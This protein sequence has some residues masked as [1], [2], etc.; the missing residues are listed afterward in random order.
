MSNLA[1]KVGAALD[2]LIGVFTPR[3]A[4]RRAQERLRALTLRGFAA[5]RVDSHTGNWGASDRHINDLLASDGARLRARVR[6]L[7]R[8]F[9]LFAR[10]VDAAVNITVSNGIKF[11][12][13]VTRPDGKLDK[14]INARVEEAW[15]EWCE[16]PE[17]SGRL[18]F[19]ELQRLLRR[20]EMEVGEALAVMALD[21]RT[22]TGS[23]A[24]M[25]QPYEPDWLSSYGAKPPR[26][27]EVMGGVEIEKRSG[28]VTAYWLEDPERIGAP[29]RIPADDVL[30]SY[31]PLR[32]GQLRGVSPL[33]PA[34]MSARDIG[35]YVGA[36]VEG[37]MMAA[38]WLAKRRTSRGGIPSPLASP[39]GGAEDERPRVQ[40]IGYNIIELLSRGEDFELISH[41]RPGARFEPTVLFIARMIAVTADLSHE[42]VTGDYRGISFSNLKGIRG[43]LIQMNRPTQRRFARQICQPIY[44][45]WLDVAHLSGRL[46]LPDYWRQRR[47]YLRSVQWLYPGIEGADVLRE[48]RAVLDQLGGALLPPQEVLARGGR[49]AREVLQ[50][51]K[52]FLDMAEEIGVPVHWGRSTV[53]QNPAA[54][55]AGES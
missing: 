35:E 27:R 15:A 42:L 16:S 30:H 40:E 41:D 32:P 48:T 10:V 6:Q 21:E 49:D 9:P 25:I 14:E 55:G 2:G 11:Q 34:V 36:E 13:R 1:H 4:A 23:P 20:Q 33:A 45:R 31:K 39:A 5:A 53:K 46:A 17:A 37:A 50:A 44:A 52:D 12:C 18:D 51:T 22:G 38:R 19:V 26:G 8:D 24:L 47:R 29:K 7:V 43:D 54:L 28:R 3:W